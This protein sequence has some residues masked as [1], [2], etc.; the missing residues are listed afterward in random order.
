LTNAKKKFDQKGE[1]CKDGKHSWERLSVLFC[2]GTNGEKFQPLLTGNAACPCALKEQW[3]DTKHLP[4]EWHSNKK[5]WITHNF[6][7]MVLKIR[8][9]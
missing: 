7:R 1:K 3:I 9:I 8:I 2:C 4:L 6:Y 5:A